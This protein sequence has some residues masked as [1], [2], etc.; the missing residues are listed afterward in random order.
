MQ[1][2]AKIVEQGKAETKAFLMLT[3]G[4]TVFF[5]GTFCSKY[6]RLTFPITDK[7]Q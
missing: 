5:A 3:A 7:R 6:D 4:K 1:P 2:A